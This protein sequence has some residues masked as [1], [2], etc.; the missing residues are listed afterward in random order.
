MERLRVLA[1]ERVRADEG[2][3]RVVNVLRSAFKYETVS[4]YLVIRMRWRRHTQSPG[5]AV[6]ALT[7]RRSFSGI[8]RR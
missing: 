2:R 6:R 7:L 5:P 4:I 3:R 8:G 1:P